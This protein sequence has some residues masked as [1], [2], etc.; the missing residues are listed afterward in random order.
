[1]DQRK[2]LSLFSFH[3]DKNLIYVLIYWIVEIFLRMIIVYQ[4]DN[5]FL[6]SKYNLSLN[7]YIFVI[8]FAISNLLSGFLILYI[9]KSIK[10]ESDYKETKNSLIYKNPIN[11]INA[12]YYVKLI[13]IS[14]LESPI[15]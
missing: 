10:I 5:C 15:I 4:Y 8:Y 3:C 2:N 6:I 13:I 12:F 9:K 14:I 1:M 11:K 7:E